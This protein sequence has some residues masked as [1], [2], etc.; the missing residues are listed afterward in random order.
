MRYFTALRYVQYDNFAERVILSEAKNL[1]KTQTL[2]LSALLE[3]LPT[4]SR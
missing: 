4:C 1:K 2:L 3:I